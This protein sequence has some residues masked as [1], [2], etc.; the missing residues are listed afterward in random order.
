MFELFICS[1][2]KVEHNNDQLRDLETRIKTLNTVLQPMED[3]DPDAESVLKEPVETFQ[4]F[5][6]HSYSFAKTRTDID[7][8]SELDALN[9]Q[10]QGVHER[11]SYKNMDYNSVEL[12]RIRSSVNYAL[13]NLT[14]RPTCQPLGMHKI[15]T[16]G[17][18]DNLCRHLTQITCQVCS[19]R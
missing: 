6:P 3:L 13:D 10:L 19:A 18:I 16:M 14:V 4:S 2:Q 17:L 8:N 9:A 1:L 12:A 7:F 15:P 5:V 11:G